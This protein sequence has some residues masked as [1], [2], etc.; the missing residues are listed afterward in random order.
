MKLGCALLAL[1]CMLATPA[2]AE[3]W[4]HHHGWPGMGWGGGWHPGYFRPQPRFYGGY[5]GFM[6]RYYG[7][8][9]MPGYGYQSY[10][11]QQHWQN[12]GSWGG[13]YSFTYCAPGQGYPIRDAYGNVVACVR[14]W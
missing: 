12:Y 4:H 11:Y 7:G 13:S 5:G 2:A 14:E 9:Y 3:H 10:G 1:C 8:G 6:P